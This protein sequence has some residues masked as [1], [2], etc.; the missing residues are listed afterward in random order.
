MSFLKLENRGWVG[1]SKRIVRGK[2]WDR[3]PKDS[4]KQAERYV[5]CTFR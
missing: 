5:M 2:I 3:K 1:A 4:K